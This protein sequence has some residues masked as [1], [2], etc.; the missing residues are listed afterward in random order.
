[1]RILDFLI[2]MFDTTPIYSTGKYINEKVKVSYTQYN[3]KLI[4][5]KKI[6]TK[7]GYPVP[8]SVLDLFAD[9]MEPEYTTIQS[10]PNYYV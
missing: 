3:D 4:P 5:I 2:E 1:M 9:F 6:R 10:E 7:E 8:N